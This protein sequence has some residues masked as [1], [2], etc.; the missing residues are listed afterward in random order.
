MIKS[1]NKL[2]FFLLILIISGQ[3]HWW[4]I[5]K[6]RG[7]GSLCCCYFQSFLVV[8]WVWERRRRRLD[9]RSAKNSISHTHMCA[10]QGNISFSFVGDSE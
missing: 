3:Q 4:E 10:Q 9:K 8:D 1:I 6:S 7:Y 2:N 5:R